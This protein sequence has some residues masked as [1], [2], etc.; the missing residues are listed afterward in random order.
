MKT[1]VPNYIQAADR[2]ELKVVSKDLHDGQIE[3]CCG[4]IKLVCEDSE[5]AVS[6][7]IDKLRVKILM[8]A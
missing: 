8:A 1:R 2:E 4:Q 6:I 5:K 7:T 3:I